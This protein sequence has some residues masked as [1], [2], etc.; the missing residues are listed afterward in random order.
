MVSTENLSSYPD[1]TIPFTVN[2]GAS[3]KRLGANIF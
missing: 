3:D 2:I 1:W